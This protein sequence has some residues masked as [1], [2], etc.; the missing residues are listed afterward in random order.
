MPD[1]RPPHP[2]LR[3][4][5]A[6]RPLPRGASLRDDRQRQQVRLKDEAELRRRNGS[7]VRPGQVLRVD[8]LV[9]TDGL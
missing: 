3:P 4:I 7:Q 1:L 9:P 2:G 6:A 5:Q 8:V